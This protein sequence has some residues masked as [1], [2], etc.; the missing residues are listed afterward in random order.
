MYMYVDNFY[1]GVA[2]FED[3]EKLG[4]AVTGTLRTDR[5]GVLDIV[6]Q[7]QKALSETNVPCGHGY[8]MYTGNFR[9]VQ[10]FAFFADRLG[11]M[12]IR[13]AKS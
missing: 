5:R 4:I 11:A 2:L 8:Y 3:L 12:K 9:M 10:N 6:K 13:T 7:L 1:K